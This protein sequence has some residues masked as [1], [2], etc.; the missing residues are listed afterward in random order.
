MLT[1]KRHT[2]ST[3][4]KPNREKE[5]LMHSVN[6][7]Y[8]WRSFARAKIL[9]LVHFVK[10]NHL[11]K[12]CVGILILVHFMKENYLE[13]LCGNWNPYPSAFYEGEPPGE[14]MRW[15]PYPSAFYE[16]ELAAKTLRDLESVS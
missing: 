10:E 13:K 1:A 9:I 6:D 11:D 7:N 15:N 8:T 4:T 3:A 16:R 2:S 12:L 5:V 14:T